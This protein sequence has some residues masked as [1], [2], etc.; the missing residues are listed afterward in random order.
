MTWLSFAILA[1]FLL[2]LVNILDKFL[3]DKVLPS[4]R[5]Y[6]FLVGAL[7]MLVFVLA[8]WYLYWPG[9]GLFFF[10]LLVGAMFPIALLFFYSALRKGEASKTLLLIGGAVPIFTLLFSILLLNDSFTYRQWIALLFLLLGTIIISWL[11][12]K[13]SFWHKVLLI[14]RTKRENKK[15]GIV[16]A[17]LAAAFFALFFVGSK[18]AFNGQEFL[19]AFIWIRG[20]SFIAVLFFLF[21]KQSRIKIFTSFKRLKSKKGLIFV[22]NQGMAAGGFLLQNYAI[23]LTSVALVSALQGVQ[24]VFII[25]LGIC[26]TIFYPKLLKENISKNIIIQKL[27][28]V[29]LIA[30]GLYFITYA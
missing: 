16:L 29:L 18:Q 1:Y 5:G 11:P 6:T 4:S 23:S 3:L 22:G 20:G 7:G 30:I 9:T 14:F 17:I 10:N 27:I 24:Y 8:P 21:H 15:R 13:Q 2:A 19:S 25:I 26:A 12:E 28:A